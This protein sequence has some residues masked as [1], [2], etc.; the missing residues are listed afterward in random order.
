MAKK[1]GVALELWVQKAFYA[2]ISF[3]AVFLVNQM[4]E[5]SRSVQELNVRIA[6]VVAQISDQAHLNQ[7]FESRLRAVEGHR[8]QGK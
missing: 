5:L 8:K 1:S 4:S 3:C 7:D 6:V 2:L